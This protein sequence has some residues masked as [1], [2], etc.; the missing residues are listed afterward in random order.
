MKQKKCH[1]YKQQIKQIEQLR[2]SKPKEFRNYFKPKSSNSKHDIS[3]EEFRD[4]F[5]TISNE[6]R[7]STNNDA[8]DFCN[9]YDFDNVDDSFPELVEPII[10]AEVKKVQK[11]YAITQTR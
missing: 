1:H 4:F 9:N 6:N 11:S 10:I 3:L 7:K 5:Q 2:K 8:E